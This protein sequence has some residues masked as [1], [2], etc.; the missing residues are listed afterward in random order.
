MTRAFA[1][2]LIALTTALG[3]SACGD[4]D[5]G[6]G[7]S[8]AGGGGVST[9]PISLPDTLGGFRDVVDASEAKGQNEPALGN[10]RKHQERTKQRTEAAYSKAYSGASSAYRQYAD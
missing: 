7:G 4:D 3:L 8:T 1:V 2:S 5:G 10:S 9:K 6:G